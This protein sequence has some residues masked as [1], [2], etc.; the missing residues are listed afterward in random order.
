MSH[1]TLRILA[2]AYLV[3]ALLLGLLW[4]AAPDVA[5]RLWLRLRQAVTATRPLAAE[6]AEAG[7]P[8]Q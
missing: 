2:G 1:R 5:Q 3:K 4:L 6:T 7:L 8:T